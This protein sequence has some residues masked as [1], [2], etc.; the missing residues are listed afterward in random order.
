M[1][2]FLKFLNVQFDQFIVIFF[3]C[4]GVSFVVILDFLYIFTNIF[5]YTVAVILFSTF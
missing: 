5:I 4:F 3:Y 1:L 2:D